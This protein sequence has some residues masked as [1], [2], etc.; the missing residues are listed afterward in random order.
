MTD[1]LAVYDLFARVDPSVSVETVSAILNAAANENAPTL[2][3]ALSMLGAL[4]GRD[5]PA[6]ETSRDAL[7][8]HLYDLR[9]V[10]GSNQGT[11]VSLAGLGNEQLVALAQADIG[12]RYALEQLLPF[13]VTGNGG[14]YAG[15]NG[16]GHLDADVLTNRYLEDRA[17]MLFW[18]LRFDSG[19]KDDNDL[20]A[21]DKSYGEEWDSRGTTDDWK[22]TDGARGL[23]LTVDG[24]GTDIHHI[25]FGSGTV[26]ALAG[27]AGEDHLYGMAGD[28]ELAGHDGDDYLEGGEGQDILDGGKGA[29]TLVGS[30]GDDTLIGGD[31][32][33]ADILEGGAGN[34]TYYAGENDLVIDTDHSGTIFYNGSDIAGMRFD[35][36]YATEGDEYCLEAASGVTV[37][38]DIATAT[39]SGLNGFCTI[40]GYGK[41]DFGVNLAKAPPVLPPAARILAGSDGP[42]ATAAAIVSSEGR[43]GFSG[44]ISGGQASSVLSGWQEFS[45]NGAAPPPDLQIDGGAD[46]DSLI[47]LAGGDTIS[48]GSGNDWAWRQAA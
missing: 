39:L 3:T 34:D 5:Y 12:C 19:A 11:V 36:L 48:G 4:Y 23:T 17:A 1:F 18:K 6:G 46:N 32:S 29:D 45:M 8:T 21:G 44:T 35:F 41:G 42:D 20:L 31:D 9:G 43:Y 10:I 30:V 38:Y 2:E 15:H 22:Y 28:D 14:L 13:A 33:E 47:G 27:A 26:D 7:Y 25:A 24:N 16:D 37:R 40:S